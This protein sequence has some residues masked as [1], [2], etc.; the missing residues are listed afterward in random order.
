MSSKAHKLQEDTFL[1]EYA[2]RDF[3][4]ALTPVGSVILSCGKLEGK[5]FD[6]MRKDFLYVKEH[7]E[8]FK[9]FNTY[10]DW[11][12]YFVKKYNVSKK[13][14]KLLTLFSDKGYRTTG[15]GEKIKLKSEKTPI[16]ALADKNNI[17]RI[18]PSY[19]NIP[20]GIMRDANE[21]KDFVA[22]ERF[23]D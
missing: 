18:P 23:Y 9:D 21:N 10:K 19:F 12:D 20:Y 2:Q 1:K 3:E 4:M 13:A 5:S 15:N 14:R 7:M 22:V 17:T 16:V 8:E 6:E 11:V